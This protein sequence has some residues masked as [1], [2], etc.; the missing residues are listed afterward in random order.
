MKNISSFCA[1]TASCRA[2]PDSNNILPQKLSFISIAVSSPE[3]ASPD[4]GD[5][6]NSKGFARA[7]MHA[8]T[9]AIAGIFPHNI[10][11]G[12]MKSHRYLSALKCLN[13]FLPKSECDIVEHQV[14]LRKSG[15]IAQTKRERLVP[16]L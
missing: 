3:S 2:K 16:Y 5:D 10:I 14:D 7:A 1:S 11:E 6:S 12:K 13:N 8:S 15:H 4:K 9:H